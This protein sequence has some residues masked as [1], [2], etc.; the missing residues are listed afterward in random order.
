MSLAWRKKKF[1]VMEEIEEAR[2]Q[3]SQADTMSSE[4]SFNHVKV[5]SASDL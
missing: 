4:K 1:F 2:G 5:Q 3:K